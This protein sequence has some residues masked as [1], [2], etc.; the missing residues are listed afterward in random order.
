MGPARLQPPRARPG[1]DERGW[2][3]Q[4]RVVRE[5][6][7]AAEQGEDVLLWACSM[8]F[9]R[10]FDSVFYPVADMANHAFKADQQEK[11]A[12]G[13]K[14]PADGDYGAPTSTARRH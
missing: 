6:A 2:R 14:R 3:A 9:S 5:R 8:A 10:N 1:T 11:V 4:A 13:E 7:R 12:R